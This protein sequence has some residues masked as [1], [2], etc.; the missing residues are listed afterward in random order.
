MIWP[1]ARIASRIVRPGARPDLAATVVPP[2]SAADRL[3]VSAADRPPVA[4]TDRP[5]VAATAPMVTAS[6]ASSATPAPDGGSPSATPCAPTA[7][8]E[9]ISAVAAP[10]QRAAGSG[11]ACINVLAQA[12]AG[13][14][15]GVDAVELLG[16]RGVRRAAAGG[17]HVLGRGHRGGQIGKLLVDRGDELL[18][19]SV[20][21]VLLPNQPQRLFRARDARRQPRAV[22]GEP[23]HFA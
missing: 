8:A 13:H 15:V 12:E 11:G 1:D 20:F 16:D 17:G 4:A 22:P 21:R 9:V 7:N 5:P 14:Q 2:V 10:R 18:C 6:T 23:P 19:L 3:A